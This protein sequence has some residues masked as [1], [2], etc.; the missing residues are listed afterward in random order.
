MNI[1]SKSSCI[2]FILLSLISS[3]IAYAEI[4][5]AAIGSVTTSMAI[6]QIFSQ[7]DSVI[8]K[9]RDTGDYVTMR[10]AMEAKDAIQ[11]WKDANMQL[12]DKAFSELNQQQQL[13]FNNA[14]QFQSKTN[15][16]VNEQLRLIQDITNQANQL[17]IDI[18]G[19]DRTF[20]TTFSPRVKPPMTMSSIT[21]HV[22]GVN[23]DKGNPTLEIKN[24]NV[25]RMLIGPMEVQYTVD[26]KSLPNE[27]TK[28]STVPLTIK[29]TTP[30][31]GFWNHVF[32]K[33]QTVTRQLPLIMLPSKIGQ[34]SYL[35]ETKSQNKIIQTFTSQAQSFSGS[36]TNDRKIAKP[37]GGWQ[38]DWEQGI[39]AFSQIQRDGQAGSCNGI[40]A[41]ESN[42]F[43]ITHSAHLD[44]I[45]QVYF[46][47]IIPKVIYGDGWQN[48]AVTGPI[49]QMVS[50]TKILPTQ[51]G[52]LLWTEDLRLPIPQD[53][54]S[55]TLQVITFDGRKRIFNG[56]G[57]D[58]FFDVI[59]S[60][61]EL[62][63]SPHQPTDL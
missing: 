23:L 55:I 63:I 43:G 5:T 11:A 53:T 12:M 33:R 17:V 22:K 35:V 34:F 47:G 16:D 15:E 42:S 37:P 8:N 36:N 41:N 50:E 28:L 54:I 49:F 18:P 10:A 13:M 62:I 31:D 46:D 51:T 19:N 2:G 48:C 26:D 27:E 6:S 38:W 59:Q 9:A 45:K 40:L 57:H 61:N 20:I 1:L 3:P 14:R 24:G 7:L 32:G 56:A 4:V 29:Y 44:Q 58:K 39:G 52:D 21:F 25:S 30:L 60:S